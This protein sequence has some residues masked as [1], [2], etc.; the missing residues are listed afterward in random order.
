MLRLEAEMGGVENIYSMNINDR[1]KVT[2]IMTF[3]NYE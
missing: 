2:E 1:D 3:S